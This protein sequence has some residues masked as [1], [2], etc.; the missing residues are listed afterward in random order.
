MHPQEYAKAIVG[1]V[2]AGLGALAAGL[3]DQVMTPVEWITVASATILAGA[4]VFGVP[5]S[6]PAAHRAETPE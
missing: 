2:L 4:V 1:A 5:N 3:A 6:D